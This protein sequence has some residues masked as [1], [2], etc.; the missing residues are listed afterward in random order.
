MNYH[1]TFAKID[2]KCPY[3]DKPY[4]DDESIYLDRCNSNK[5]GCTI[6]KCECEMRFGMTYDITGKAVSFKLKKIKNGKPITK[7][8]F[9]AFPN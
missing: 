2:F 7:N 6:I 1:I 3:C 9:E 5:S 8:K 4:K